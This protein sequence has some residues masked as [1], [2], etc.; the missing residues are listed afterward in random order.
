MTLLYRG[1]ACR[2]CGGL[3]RCSAIAVCQ[4][5]VCRYFTAKECASGGYQNDSQCKDNGFV[6]I[7][8]RLPKG[9]FIALGNDDFRQC[10]CQQETFCTKED[11]V[12]SGKVAALIWCTLRHVGAV[13]G[14]SAVSRMLRLSWRLST[15]LTAAALRILLVAAALCILLIAAALRILLIAALAVGIAGSGLIRWC[16]SAARTSGRVAALGHLRHVRSLC[17][18]L[19]ITHGEKHG[20]AQRQ[21][22]HDGNGVLDPIF[23]KSFSYR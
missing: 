23:L 12:E 2:L 11:V 13:S 10:Q 20:A 14:L 7:K 5:V 6:S 19:C 21:H 8:E 18:R 16:P 22:H 4:H 9:S 3:P 1:V 17:M 15:L